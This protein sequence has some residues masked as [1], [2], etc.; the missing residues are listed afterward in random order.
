MK[1]M[2]NIKKILLQGRRSRS[3]DSSLL[4]S[5]SVVQPPASK[6]V[7]NAASKT[8]QESIVDALDPENIAAKK[9]KVEEEKKLPKDVQDKVNM[10]AFELVVGEALPIRIV[11]SK[12]I[13]VT[14]LRKLNA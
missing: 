12:F 9:Q 4:P 13:S 2:L 10:R 3:P 8:K 1:S 7:C 14:I 11:E 5:S 6:K